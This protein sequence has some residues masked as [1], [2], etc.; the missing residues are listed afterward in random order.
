MAE[1]DIRAGVENLLLNCGG[2]ARGERLLILCEEPNEAYYCPRIAEAVR[3][4]AAACGIDTVTRI[5]PFDP[6]G[7]ELSADLTREMESAHR[8]LFLSRC[9]DQLRF[10]EKMRGVR[11]IMSYALD[12]AALSSGFGTAHHRGFVAL[13][14]AVNALLAQAANIRVTCPLGTDFSGPGAVFPPGPADVTVDRFP[15][16]VFA[17]VPVGG[18]SGTIVQDGF[19]VGTGSRFYTPYGVPLRR[20]VAIHF[21]EA[22]LREIT[23]EPEDV[24]TVEAHYRHV[25][26]LF[27]LEPFTLHSW[28]AGIH[29]GCAHS[30]PAAA[31]FERWSGSAFG[32]PRLLHVHTCGD[33]APGEISLNVLD[34]TITVDG[35]EIWSAGCLD[36]ARVPGGSEILARYPCVGAVFD[37]PCREVGQGP[38][39]RLCGVTPGA[40]RP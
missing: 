14:D 30:A 32:N 7:T 8:T 9:G 39:G 16:L 29:P 25:G 40:P 28:H 3:T 10:S 18:F 1:P 20:P 24:A 36:P 37:A 2:M 38:D 6:L 31:N 26:G 17:P 11:P 15:M 12:V 27:G 33:Y 23:G 34:P 13:R 21:E 19:L 4:H 22:R 35:V 5:V